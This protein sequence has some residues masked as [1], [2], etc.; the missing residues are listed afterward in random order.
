VVRWEWRER[1]AAEGG[2]EGV[3]VVVGAAGVRVGVVE[4]RGTPEAET[5]GGTSPEVEDSAVVVLVAS[6]T[7][8]PPISASISARSSGDL[9]E[10]EGREGGERSGTGRRGRGR[11]V[12][13]RRRG[14]GALSPLVDCE[15]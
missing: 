9:H 12:R 5:G 2:E 1:E 14:R 13:A 8:A 7:G 10:R 4:V 15:R 11:E 3:A 6:G